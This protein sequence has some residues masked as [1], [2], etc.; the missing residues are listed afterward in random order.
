MIVFDIGAH[1]GEDSEYYLA[2]GYKVIAF[3]CDPRNIKILEEKFNLEI[4]QGSLVLEKRALL[5]GGGEGK[6]ATF[7]A[8][9]NSVWGT[10]NPEWSFRNEKLGSR[11]HQVALDTID[12]RDIY[13]L[14]GYPFY[15][16]IDIEGSDLSVLESLKEVQAR[17]RPRY[18]SI[19]STK[20]SW[21]ALLEEFALFEALGYSK[22]AIVPQL[23]NGRKIS[24]WNSSGGVSISFRHKKQ[25]SGPFGPDLPEKWITRK[26]AIMIYKFIFFRYK[27]FGDDG[28]FAPSKIKIGVLCL[29]YRVFLRTFKLYPNWF[30]T[31]ALRE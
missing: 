12:P 26:K 6:K 22:F 5:K 18:L 27:F 17:N 31:H 10:L 2:R 8:A 15:M 4:D 9:E 14:Y 25:S 16:K 21:S 13:C 1:Q 23:N 28:F 29:L 20:V 3:E 7:Y 11:A 19:E 30:D 24:R